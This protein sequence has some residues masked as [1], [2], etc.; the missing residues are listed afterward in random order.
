MF[1]TMI[2]QFQ[3]FLEAYDGYYSRKALMEM[4]DITSKNTLNTWM[5]EKRLSFYQID[6]KIVIKESN[7]KSF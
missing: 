3:Q 2:K 1:E 7:L 6:T 4:F 5:K